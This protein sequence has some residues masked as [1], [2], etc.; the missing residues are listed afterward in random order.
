M[1]V[2]IE[3]IL[4]IKLAPLIEMQQEPGNQHQLFSLTDKMV[5]ES[6]LIVN[7]RTILNFKHICTKS[8]SKVTEYLQV[9]DYQGCLRDREAI[10]RAFAA[11]RET[12]EAKHNRNFLVQQAPISKL[13]DLPGIQNVRMYQLVNVAERLLHIG[14]GGRPGTGAVQFKTRTTWIVERNYLLAATALVTAMLNGNDSAPNYVVQE[15]AVLLK[16]RELLCKFLTSDTNLS[17]HEVVAVDTEGHFLWSPFTL[18]CDLYLH[19]LKEHAQKYV[20]VWDKAETLAGLLSNRDAFMK[21]LR[22]VTS[23]DPIQKVEYNVM[24]GAASFTPG[25]GVT[26]DVINEILTPGTYID[27]T[28]VWEFLVKICDSPA[29]NVKHVPII[30][31]THQDFK[32][33]LPEDIFDKVVKPLHDA[34]ALADCDDPETLLIP[35]FSGG[36]YSVGFISGTTMF[37]NDSLA[38]NRGYTELPLQRVTD[39]VEDLYTRRESLSTGDQ[40]TVEDVRDRLLKVAVKRVVDLGGYPAIQQLP[41]SEDCFP[42]SVVVL[43]GRLS[44]KHQDA[45]LH[46]WHDGVG[47][48]LVRV[49]LAEVLVTGKWVLPSKDQTDRMIQAVPNL[50]HSVGGI[51][52]SRV[53]I[54]DPINTASG[55]A[56]D[57]DIVEDEVGGGSGLAVNELVDVGGTTDANDEAEECEIS[58]E[59]VEALLRTLCSDVDPVTSHVQHATRTT[60]VPVASSH[61]RAPAEEVSSTASI[62][63]DCGHSHEMK[64]FISAE[65][66]SG[67]PEN[68]PPDMLTAFLQAK[69]NTE[70]GCSLSKD[71]G[72]SKVRDVARYKCA[73]ARTDEKCK[74]VFR[75]RAHQQDG[76]ENYTFTLNDTVIL[77]HS[78]CVQPNTNPMVLSNR[79]QLPED[80]YASLYQFARSK[81]KIQNLRDHVEQYV[82]D[83]DVPFTSVQK[84]LLRSIQKSARSAEKSGRSTEQLISKLQRIASAD[85]SFFFRYQLDS[86]N[87]LTRLF[88]Q[89]T[90]IP[91]TNTF[92]YIL[93]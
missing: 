4:G 27:G 84:S 81:A 89:V 76:Q 46:M 2:Y 41:K 69:F 10:L 8:V 80:L 63:K 57:S 35:V 53:V 86:E 11:V 61:S 43:L 6:A 19:D 52:A 32:D 88:L 38:D 20:V 18:T 79:L 9:D 68:T 78:H 85:K 31:L 48:L 90:N 13:L 23:E 16:N 49:W 70:T 50:P 73:R 51:Y 29:A 75:V 7:V 26:L 66:L 92:A 71:Y 3:V 24:A 12:V 54:A 74:F 40:K 5:C 83:H 39:A 33:Y 14:N 17:L 21:K 55:N 44:P 47:G 59:D 82:E 77:T 42:A 36:H 65:F 64:D 58:S 56:D 37:V 1:I 45:L 15:K 22:G 87:R 72:K 67:L 25:A 34:L 30:Y 91:A 93:P 62:C 28:A 60:S